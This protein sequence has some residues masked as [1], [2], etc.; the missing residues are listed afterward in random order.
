L[1]DR[2]IDRGRG[3]TAL[4]VEVGDPSA[5]HT[6]LDK[7][8]TGAT[9]EPWGSMD[10][11]C[12][13]RY[14]GWHG[15]PIPPLEIQPGSTFTSTVTAAPVLPRRAATYGRVAMLLLRS[16]QL[17]RL[18]PVQLAA[19][20][21]WVLAGGSL[22]LSVTRPE[23]LRHPALTGLVG[24]S[25]E[26]GPVADETRSEVSVP[27]EAQVSRNRRTPPAPDEPLS[28]EL[29]A[30]LVGYAG[31]NLR[32]SVLGATATYGLGEVHLLALD[33][34]R[35]PAVDSPWV[36]VRL[37]ALLRR[38]ADRQ[39]QLVFPIGTEPMEV[40]EVRS[41]LDPN[42]GTRW[43]VGVSVLLLMAYAVLAGPV[44]FSV[45]RRRGQ[46]L[47]A[48]PTLFLLSGATFLAIVLLAVFSKGLGGRARHLTLVEAGA[49][50]SVGV[51]RRHRAFFVASAR[52]MPV[53]AEHALAVLATPIERD[54][55]RRTDRLAL[56]RDTLRL[57]NLGLRPWEVGLV[58]EDAFVELGEGIAL[59]RGGTGETEVV[60]RSGRVLRG[61]IL[62]DSGKG[63]RWLAR[64]EPGQRASSSA[65]EAVSFLSHRPSSS[66]LATHLLNMHSQVEEFDARL[67]GLGSAWAAIEDSA[68]LGTDWLPV[69]VPT[70]L[71]QL[72]GGE[73][74]GTDSGLRIEHD[75]TLVRV[76]GYGGAP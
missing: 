37:I 61:L 45:W 25:I 72:E 56:D 21:G 52:T 9:W 33:P 16:E 74:R 18:D 3:A 68:T 35:R 31:G 50:T 5:L 42:E 76:V 17:T 15:G 65:F 28:P 6:H 75:R 26:V 12:S 22:A 44:N 63:T 66:R 71:A 53:A 36:H 69:D 47:R 29:L 64:L 13:R 20:S 30:L 60:N 23:D 73:G 70:L 14:S 55:E 27:P 46:P 40:E 32:P 11:S 24:G 41:Y 49:G 1:I 62:S 7:L 43:V 34:A 57:T 58:A 39:A 4:F 38:A 54:K 48:L 59:V 51:A 8:P 67:P 10:E 19:L 2:P